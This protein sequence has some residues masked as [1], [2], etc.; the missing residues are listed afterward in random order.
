MKSYMHLIELA[1]SKGY[2]I[3][4]YDGEEWCR[5]LSDDKA[6]IIDDIEGVEEAILRI[7][8]DPTPEDEA[9]KIKLNGMVVVGTATIIPYGVSD[10]ETVSDTSMSP[11]FEELD[12]VLEE[13]YPDYF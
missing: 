4:V 7:Y 2:V 1:L 8:R 13:K 5:K 10:H 11:F 9:H 3:S 12:K 6:A